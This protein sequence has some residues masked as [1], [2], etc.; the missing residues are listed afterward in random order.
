M[1]LTSSTPPP[2]DNPTVGILHSEVIEVEFIGV[3]NLLSSC[4]AVLV[5]ESSHR[6]TRLIMEPVRDKQLE[7]RDGESQS[8]LVDE[9]SFGVLKGVLFIVECYMVIKKKGWKSL[10]R[11][12]KDRG[13][14][15]R[16]FQLF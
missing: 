10:I 11:L 14:I 7:N 4:L 3:D 13:K 9:S 6:D 1:P 2:D 5:F 12:P 8:L 15:L 16:D